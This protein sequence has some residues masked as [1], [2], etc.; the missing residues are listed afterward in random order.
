[1]AIS[2]FCYPEIL[3]VLEGDSLFL[4]TT[5]F[6]WSKMAQPP[7]INAWL[8]SLLLQFFNIPFIGGLVVSACLFLISMLTL[9]VSKATG[10]RYYPE[11]TILPALISGLVFPMFVSVQIEE[12]T[13]LLGILCYLHLKMRK[14]R[15]VFCGIFSAIGFTLLSFP[16]LL[17]GL[18]LFSLAEWKIYRSTIY[19]A[20]IPF[21]FIIIDVILIQISSQNIGFIPFDRRYLTIYSI[22]DNGQEILFLLMNIATAVVLYALSKAEKTKMKSWIGFVSGLAA[23][24]VS[25]ALFHSNKTMRYNENCY[26]YVSLAETNNWQ[27]LL[28]EI[29]QDE[30]IDSELKQKYALLAESASGTLPDHLFQ[31]SINN[32]EDFL[33]RHQR[34]AFSCIFNRQFYAHIG[35]YDEAMHNAFEYAMQQT[36]G[37]CFSSLRHMTEYAIATGDFPVAEKYLTI[38]GKSM[39]HGTFIAEQK[40]KIEEMK[41]S[42][43]TPSVPLRYDNFIGGYPFNSEMI[44]LLQEFPQN[45]K[46]LDYLL[47]GLLLQKDLVK[48]RIILRGFPLYKEK[49]L[50]A[51]Y[52][53]ASAM[54]SAEGGTIKD[55]FSY[56]SG[57]DQSFRDFYS[58]YRSN[59]AEAASVY[60]TTYWRYFF[61]EP[62]PEESSPQIVKGH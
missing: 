30:D 9:A 25:L 44:R 13:L 54:I 5:D 47:C 17:S 57:Y 49:N 27:R 6:F 31:Y 39:T 33:F 50:P 8:T 62:L 26:H 36:N 51:A 1:M 37:N 18:L 55:L 56:D 20:F 11:I 21:S 38:L 46:I 60:P 52:A 19:K 32:P 42:G 15:L 48:F 40:K 28:E 16:T 61:F 12:I 22:A 29:R 2:T 59:S 45:K 24:I 35:I 10:N 14:W 53:E 34:N 43:K 4:L 7:G 3:K 58:T 41:E 23:V